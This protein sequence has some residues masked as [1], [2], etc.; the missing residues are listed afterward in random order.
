MTMLDQAFKF[1]IHICLIQRG[2]HKFVLY[3]VII[4]KLI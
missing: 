4:S 3:F 2:R 1:L